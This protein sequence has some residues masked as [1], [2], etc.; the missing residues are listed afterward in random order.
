VQR[1]K[2]TRTFTLFILFLLPPPRFRLV[3]SLRVCAS[4]E[5]LQRREGWTTGQESHTNEKHTRRRIRL[6]RNGQARVACL[7]FANCT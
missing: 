4:F 5:G 7:L 1:G 2:R 3:L 6:E